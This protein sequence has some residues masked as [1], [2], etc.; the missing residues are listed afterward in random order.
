[1]ASQPYTKEFYESLRNGAMRSAE[2]IAPLVLKFV[3]AHSVIDVGCGEGDWLAAF[4]K[5]G[6]E[7]ILG[8]DGEHVDQDHLQIP[9]RQFHVADLTKPLRIGRVFDLAVSLE[10]AEHLPADCAAIFVESLVRLAPAVLF[11]AAIP[12]QGGTHHV[13]EQ[14]PDTWA[15]LF[16]ERDYLAVDLVRKRVWKDESVDWWYAQNTML[17]VHPHLLETNSALR[18]EFEQTNPDQLSLVHPRK[19]VEV[20]APPPAPSWG[21]KGASLLLM[22][23]VKNA[24]RRRISSMLGNATPEAKNGNAANTKS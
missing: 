10:V 1:M 5:A 18:T 3:P 20:A 21:V 19:Y 11:S 15:G 16:R 12:F 2:V 13:N 9:Q 14:W 4:Q 6:V 23:S 22:A 17:F 7:D 24:V 8:I